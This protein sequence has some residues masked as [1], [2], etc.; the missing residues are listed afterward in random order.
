[1]IDCG[2]DN[3]SAYKKINVVSGLNGS[4]QRIDE[5]NI[6]YNVISIMDV[7]LFGFIHSQT[8]IITEINKKEGSIIH[9]DKPWWLIFPNKK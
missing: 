9:V 1:L 7:K 2:L 6:S 4:I 5:N 3:Q 8:K